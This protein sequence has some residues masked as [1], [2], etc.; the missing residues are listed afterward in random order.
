MRRFENTD[1][2]LGDILHSLENPS[3]LPFISSGKYSLYNTFT[4]YRESRVSIKR[5]TKIIIDAFLIHDL[6]Q[7]PRNPLQVVPFNVLILVKFSSLLP[8]STFFL[9]VYCL[10]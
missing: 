1:G 5:D 6:V 4:K 7:Q 10:N 9:E 8:I 3:L 2:A